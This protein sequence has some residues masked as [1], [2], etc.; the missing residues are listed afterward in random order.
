MLDRLGVDWRKAGIDDVRLAYLDHLRG[1]AAGRMG[2][3]GMDLASERAMTERV[4]R[5]IR[6]LELAEKRG[7]L[8]AVDQ[9]E[10][11]YGQMVDAFKS[12][13]LALPDKI[14][15][16]IRTLHGVDVDVELINGHIYS[17]L[18]Q[19]SGYD[20]DSEADPEASG[21]ASGAAGENEVDG[22]V[23]ALS[24]PL[25]QSVSVAG[26]IQP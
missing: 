14:V 3:D 8:V 22:L 12:D 16:E 5:E 24:A 9:L 6:I 18:E 21:Q 15:E 2:D 26:E 11:H 7:E 17:S 10:K 19:L 23:A 20:P 13:L 4:N 1:V 25:S